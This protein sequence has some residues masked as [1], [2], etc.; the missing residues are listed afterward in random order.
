[1]N[2]NRRQFTAGALA[3]T[4]GATLWRGGWAVAGNLEG[5]E[6]TVG[7]IKS[8]KCDEPAFHNLKF[9]DA[10][11]AEI[12]SRKVYIWWE[13]QGRSGGVWHVLSAI[14]THLKCKV[15]YSSEEHKFICPCHKSEYDLSGKVIHKPA[16]KNLPDYSED[17]LER[18]GKLIIKYRA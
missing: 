12:A 10:D 17:A 15:G 1:M 14:C 5:A 2:I 9:M 7:D 3:A 6:A 18:E 11:G 8:I 16:K 4:L 13:Q